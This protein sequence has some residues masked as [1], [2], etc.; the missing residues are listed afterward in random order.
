MLAPHIKKKVDELWN[1]FWA[2]GL[3]NPLVAVEQ[4][5][6]LL[7]LKRLEDIDLKRQQRGFPSIYVGNE[8]CKWSYIRQE[9]T[10]P[11][12]LIDKVFPW[13]RELDKHFTSASAEGTELSSL[14]NRMADA[15]FQLDPNKGKVLSDAIDAIDQLFARAGEGSAAQDVMGDTFEYLLSEVATAGKNGQFRTPRHLIR[16]MVELLDPVP[17]QRVIDPAAGTG[18]FLFSTQQYLMR[19][20]SAQDNV[21]LEWDG[22]PHRTDGAA[23]NPEQYAAIHKGANFVGLDND[24]T[25]ARIGWMNLVLHDVADPHLVQGDSLSKREGK[26]QLKQL[27]ESEAYD[28]VLANPP[29]TG[30]VD[31]GDLEPDSTLFPRVGGGGKKKEDSITNKSELLFLWLMLDLLRVGGRCAVIIPEGV[32]FGNTDAHIRLRRELLTEHVVEGVI[33]LPSGVFQPYTGVKT[34]ILIFRKETRREAKRPLTD[35]RM[36]HTEQVWFYEVE[37]DGYTLD[38][39]RSPRPGQRNDLWDALEK[40]KA[41]LANGS[42]GAARN[43]TI[44]LQPKFWQERWRQALLRDSA[45]TLTP[46]GEAF[47]SSPDTSVWDGQVWGIHELFPDIPADPEAAEILVRNNSSRMLVD[48][49]VQYFG[50]SSHPIWA[51]WHETGTPEKPMNAEHALA[52]WRKAIRVPQQDFNRAAREVQKFFEPEDGPALRVWK[53]IVKDALEAGLSFYETAVSKAPTVKLA[54]VEPVV[55]LTAALEDIARGVAKLDGFDVTLRSP[56]VDQAVELKASKH[57]VVPVRAWARNDEWQSEDGQFVG[58]HGADGLVRPAYVEAMQATCLYDE[59]GALNVDLLDPDCIEAREWN[60]SSG[61]YKPFDL[62]QLKSDK[63]VS[64]LIGE[65]KA[66]E[67]DIIQGLDRLLAMVGGLK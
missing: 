30:I 65:L 13:L 10:N 58:S 29:F 61:Q 6:Y 49:V 16:F 2:A 20:Y 8:D 42:D 5:T 24:R 54:V 4:I 66:T 37:E 3:T 23:A 55:D 46:A 14:N 9:K 19:K 39:K 18:G 60:L 64:E 35:S 7:F 56:A 33:S 12:H 26:P 67:Q 38:A 17:G 51:Q 48:F 21:V 41:W 36:P 59:K 1:R 27:L 15:Y 44:L 40:F 53:D 31:S 32:L 47:A 45:D 11:A 57:W 28:F 22:T 50:A 52:D 62:A 43:K 25:M 63:S 34:S